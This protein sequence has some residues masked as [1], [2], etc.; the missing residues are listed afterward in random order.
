[1]NLFYNETQISGGPLVL[2]HAMP[3]AQSVALGIFI[4]VGSRDESE[5]QAGITHALEHML[6]KGAKQMD[7]HQLAEKLDELGGNANAFTSRERTCFHLH[8]L[9]EH[10][11]EALDVLTSMVREPTLPEAEWQR[12]RDVIFAEM[13][14]VEDSPEEWIADRHLASLFP[15]HVLGQPVL[16]A[17]E[18]LST[19]SSRDLRSYLQRWY[20]PP[21]LAVVAAGRLEHKQLVDAIA[22]QRWSAAEHGGRRTRPAEFGSGVQA[23]PRA[24]EQAQLLV[25]FPGIHSTSSERPVAW[26]ANQILGGSMS[27]RLFREIREKRGLAYSIGS[28]LS[29][30]SD[31][32]AWSISCGM[33]PARGAECI[34]VLEDVLDG[35]SA[36][37]R[38]E[39]L[40]R[41]KRQLEVQFRMGLE[42]VE[43]QMLYLGSRLDE[44]VIKSPLLWLEEIHAVELKTLQDWIS[45]HMSQG[46]LWSIAA[47]E[48]ALA[49][50]C[51]RIRP[52]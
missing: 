15:R 20:C 32:G 10:W 17:H 8:V 1:M 43:G 45:R 23:L 40:A 16:G 31:I 24:G 33:E 36:S 5:S 7:V 30:F 26:L 21:G 42:S 4:N 29:M 25:S 51:D 50:I 3:A 19:F 47:P 35:Y 46:K 6:F 11:Q 2:S 48:K 28:H 27:S 37:V 34:P 44:Q 39:E 12:E 13:A 49:H 22:R 18:S 52:C 9:H 38:D 14:M 41:A